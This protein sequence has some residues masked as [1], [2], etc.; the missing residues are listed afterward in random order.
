MGRNSFPSRRPFQRP[1]RSAPSDE[2]QFPYAAN[3]TLS[4]ISPLPS[5]PTSE[6]ERRRR[7]EPWR[8]GRLAR[9]RARAVSP[10]RRSV[11]LA[12]LRRAHGRGTGCLFS[13][14]APD[15]DPHAS[16]S[17]LLAQPR[18]YGAEEAPD[19]CSPQ[20]PPRPRK[21]RIFFPTAE[22]NFSICCY[23]LLWIAVEL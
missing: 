2:D 17:S 14:A 16:T 8:R 3:Q 6:R 21:G 22:T 5:Q 15:L 20:G 13:G 11:E 18:R 4:N 10:A 1:V 19:V 23:V 7:P 9:R 12:G